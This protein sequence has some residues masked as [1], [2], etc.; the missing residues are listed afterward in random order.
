[1]ASPKADRLVRLW[2][3]D[4]RQARYSEW[5]NWYAPLTDFP[6]ALLDPNGYYLVPSPDSLSLPGIHV[7][8]QINVPGLIST[9]P[10]Y[11]RMQVLGAPASDEDSEG[12]TAVGA[13]FGKSEENRIVEEAAV[14]LVRKTYLQEGWQVVSVEEKRCGFD[15]HC[16]RNKEEVHV[17]VKGVAGVER[18]FVITA[19]ELRCALDDEQFVLALVTAALSSQPVLERLPASSFRS[20]FTFA[21]IQ[22]WANPAQADGRGTARPNKGFAADAKKRRG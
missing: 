9:L 7:K 19:G 2:G 16:I 11:V 5:G 10:G 6:A 17:E 8:K 4:V 20:G 22:Y 18:R 12:E 3:L 15:L 13:G 1:M 21:P 14:N